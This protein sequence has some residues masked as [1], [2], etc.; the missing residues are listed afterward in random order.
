M[1]LAFNANSSPIF[2]TTITAALQE[3][4]KQT[5][6]DILIHPL[7][8]QLYSCDS[9]SATLTLLRSQV[10][11][12]DKSQNERLT[13]WLEPTVNVMCAFSATFGIDVGT[14]I[15]SPSN[16]L[17]AGIGI[18]LRAVKDRLGNYTEV[19][20]SEAMTKIILNTIVDL[21]LILGIV[22]K[23]VRQGRT[24]IEFSQET[25]RKKGNRGVASAARPIDARGSRGSNRIPGDP[26]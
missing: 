6:I 13:Q 10:Q 19:R 4:E 2:E 5:K 20:P 9:P 22:T 18:L 7:A 24:S 21:F 12:F 25:G 11:A 16:V 1:A 26:S 3:Y 14:M 17:F 8:T 23:E 15:S